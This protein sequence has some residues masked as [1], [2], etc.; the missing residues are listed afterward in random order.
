MYVILDD[1]SNR[2]LVRSD[3]FELFNIKGQS[4]PYSLKT[5]AGLVETSGRKAEGFQIESLDG[6]TSL[7]LPPLIECNEI[8][9]DRTEIPTPDA[10]RFHPHL[11][12]VAPYIPELDHTA[13][14]LILLG[15]DLIRV[16]KVLQQVNGPP[17]APFA[18][19]LEL[20]WVLVGEVCLGGAHRPV[21]GTFKT[22]V[23]ENGRPSILTPCKAPIKLTQTLSHGGEQRSKSTKPSLDSLGQ[24]VFKET[25]YDNR[26][27]PSI[28]DTIFLEIMDQ[29][30]YRDES[31]NW[32]A[33]L[34]FRVPRQRLSN[35]REQVFT[36]F[37]ALEKTLGRKPEMKEQFLEL[38]EKMLERKHAEVAP[39]LEH[40]EE[41]WYLPTF[42]VYHPQKPGNIRVVFDSSAKY[43]G[44]SLNDVLL[45]GPDLNNSLIGVLIRFRKEQVAVIADIQQMFHCFLVRNNHRNYLRFLW[46]RDN[47][48][49]KDVIDYRMRVH[50]FG[51]SPSPSVAIYGLRRAIQE[52]ADQHGADTVQF[53]ERHFYVDDGLISLPTDA[54]AIS[55]LRRTQASL[56]ESNL[57]LHK[58]ASNSDAVLQAFAPEDRAVL[59]SLD[60]SGDATPVQRSLGLLWETT[61]DTFTFAISEEKK[62]FTRRGVL[63]TV[64]SIFDPL[65]MVAPV[66]IEGK[67]L[68]RALSVDT[69]DWDAPLPEEKLKQW[70]S[71]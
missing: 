2:S 26:P 37:A 67:S 23:L 70:E 5:C 10:A 12:S 65:G 13:E 51:N 46:Y 45:T 29:Q 31:N 16:H 47:D 55:L 42:G 66:T 30:V 63:S 44:T 54:D 59:K 22:N 60:F 71:W 52:G 61:T 68:L 9:N 28:E 39:P 64:N 69:C 3:F 33:P 43:S 19:K 48:M 50:V 1:Q 4:F 21:V 57:R 58:F 56:S 6:Q 8:L 24:K 62:P 36:R 15:R 7:P 49:S 53:V 14:I 32:V 34:P 27:A 35:N 17:D 18:Q 41:C 25:E 20:G 40:N 38:M 11:R